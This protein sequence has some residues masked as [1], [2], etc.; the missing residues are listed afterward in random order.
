[1]ADFISFCFLLLKDIIPMVQQAANTTVTNRHLIKAM[2]I[3]VTKNYL[4]MWK[5]WS[6][7]SIYLKMCRHERRM[8]DPASLSLKLIFWPLRS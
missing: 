2:L 5:T 8:H 6:K 4:C 7:I 1:M 3:N